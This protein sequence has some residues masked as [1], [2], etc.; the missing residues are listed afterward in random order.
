VPDRCAWTASTKACICLLRT[1][2]DQDRVPG[3]PG[4]PAVKLTI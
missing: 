4:K 3:W 1:T 2:P